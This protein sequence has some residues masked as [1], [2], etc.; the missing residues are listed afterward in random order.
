[1]NRPTEN[2][3]ESPPESAQSPGPTRKKRR[4]PPQQR[5][6]TVLALQ[7]KIFGGLMILVG[8]LLTTAAWWLSAIAVIGLG[9]MVAGFGLAAFR[10]W[11]WFVAVALLVPLAIGSLVLIVVA[12]IY[13]GKI[14]I[15]LFFAP[16]YA[17]YVLWV[18]CSRGGRQ[19]YQE[20]REAIARAKDNPDSIAGRLYRKR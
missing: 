19:R 7:L 17:A 8:L 5:D 1:M 16:A 14:G 10:P 9:V 20:I 11:A 6:Y 15:S 12:T 18:L 3:F 4:K 2:P 13:Y